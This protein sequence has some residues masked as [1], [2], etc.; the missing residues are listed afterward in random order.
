MFTTSQSSVKDLF[1][2]DV[3][4]FFDAHNIYYSE[5]LSVV[6]KTGGVHP[7]DFHFQR[8]KK[9]PERFCKTIN[10]LTR[11]TRDTAIF[12]WLD[13]EDVRDSSSQLIVL[14]NDENT[15]RRDDINAFKNYE[16]E[17]ICFSDADK[18]LEKF[19]A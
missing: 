6:G 14:I 10:R 12:G 2:D 9:Q 11:T 8:S 18:N 15:V 19:C 7:Y 3:K 13:T 17:P 5:N 1:N 16:I 4:S